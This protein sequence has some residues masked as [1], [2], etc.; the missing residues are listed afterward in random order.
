M[1]T[2]CVQTPTTTCLSVP[3]QHLKVIEVLYS[4]SGVH[5]NGVYELVGTCGIVALA[6]VLITLLVV[7]EMKSA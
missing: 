7:R 6:A 5:S 1:T 2:S 3:T 4:T